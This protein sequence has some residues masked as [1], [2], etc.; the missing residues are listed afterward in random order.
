MP[1]KSNKD[2]TVSSDCISEIEKNLK[3]YSACIIGCGLGCNED[4][5]KVVSAI[6]SHDDIPMLVD[7]DGINSICNDVSILRHTSFP[8]VLTP[9][10]AE[11]ARLCH[12]STE[13]VLKNKI[14]LGK[15]FS[16]DH[17]AVLVLK[18]AHTLVFT[19]D[20]M[21]YI[22]L[23]GNNGLAK[24]GSGDILS[25]MISGF[26]AQGISPVMSAV[27]GVY[28]HGLAADKCAERLSKT[29]MLPS[30]I[31]KDLCEIFLK[32]GR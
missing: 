14:E 1:L 28:L 22:N 17:N 12:C 30:D 11:M 32:N 2:G 16:C 18:G 24:G 9:H 4:T 5:K 7:A 25:G 10:P 6:I 21:I 3:N 8:V 27:C 15:K 20:G 19:P 26:L 29:A 31:F 23:T 13:E